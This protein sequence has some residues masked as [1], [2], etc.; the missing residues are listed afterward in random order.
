[1]ISEAS[2][3]GASILV[4]DDQ[5]ESAELLEQALR[6]EGYTNVTSTLDSRQVA[7]L[8]RVSRYDLI[9]LD[10]MM[11]GL[12]GFGVLEGLRALETDSY[13]SVLAVT[14]SSEQRVRALKSGAKDFVSKP[15]DLS[16]LLTRVH[17]LL[18]VRLLHAADRAHVKALQLLS[19]QDPLTGLVNRRGAD[20]R[21]QFALAHAHRHRGAIAVIYLDLDGFK[22]VNDTWGHGVG[23]LLLES[24]AGRLLAAV[25]TRRA[26]ES[27]SLPP[28]ER[29][30][31]P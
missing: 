22:A 11:P 13:L 23:D 8:H 21:V 3:L 31:P 10:L 27:P 30:R 18:E 4:V 6:G 9:L 2:I 24:V 20:E 17:N 26:P 14:A 19:R 12:D 16:E 5:A 25:R 7:E 15:F 1:M 28:R 29:T